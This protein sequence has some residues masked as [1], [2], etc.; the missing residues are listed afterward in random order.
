LVYL[1]VDAVYDSLRQMLIFYEYSGREPNFELTEKIS[2]YERNARTRDDDKKA[3]A[4]V[5]AKDPEIL[6]RLIA[7]EPGRKNPKS[8]VRCRISNGFKL[9]GKIILSL[10]S[11][12]RS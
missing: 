3:A 6:F 11:G 5:T 12:I 1:F 2:L 9:H 10:F 4:F 7:F 8:F